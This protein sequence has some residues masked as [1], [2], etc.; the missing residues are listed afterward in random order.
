[1]QK[2]IVC[3]LTGEHANYE[4]DECPEFELDEK[5]KSKILA[6]KEKRQKD[7]N[8]SAIMGAVATFLGLVRLFFGLSKGLLFIYS[9]VIIIAGA[10]VTYKGLRQQQ[11]QF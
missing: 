3:S 6:E 9:I 1:M 8:T 5:A 10:I 7:N 11:K 4:E 2:G